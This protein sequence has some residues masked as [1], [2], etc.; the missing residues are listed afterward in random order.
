MT[1]QGLSLERASFRYRELL[2]LRETDFSLPR[3]GTVVVAGTSPAH[4]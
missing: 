1:A 4:R 2:V 3:G